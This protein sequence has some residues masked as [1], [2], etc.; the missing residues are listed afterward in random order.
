MGI[1]ASCQPNYPQ[2]NDFVLLIR[3]ANKFIRA[4]R[5]I[6]CITEKVLIQT[7]F[8][9]LEK[10]LQGCDL[11]LPWGSPD[12]SWH[13]SPQLKEYFNKIRLVIPKYKKISKIFSLIHPDIQS[14]TQ[15][16]LAQ[17]YAVIAFLW[18]MFY[19][20]NNAVKHFYQSDIL[21][22]IY[23]DDNKSIETM[24]SILEKIY[25]TSKDGFIPAHCLIIPTCSF[26][27]V[28][29]QIDSFED[30]NI[31]TGPKTYHSVSDPEMINEPFCSLTPIQIEVFLTMTPPINKQSKIDKIH[32]DINILIDRLNA[33]PIKTFKDDWDED[34]WRRNRKFL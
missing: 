15:H 2:F 7:F 5:H 10:I 31:I 17:V 8:E 29:G 30:G 1:S 13:L 18:L 26:R 32:E 27:L 21:H 33:P 20:G 28:H 34:F 4:D 11:Q 16:Q 23:G 14:N 6:W 24:L 3:N 19:D 25:F 22:F 9:N 12:K